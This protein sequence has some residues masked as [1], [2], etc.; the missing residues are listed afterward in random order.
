MNVYPSSQ[1]G[2]SVPVGSVVA[3]PNSSE[4]TS[5]GVWLE[6]NGQAIPSQYKKLIALIGSK[7][8]NY[9]GVFLRGYGSQTLSSWQNFPMKQSNQ[10]YFSGPLG[11][12]VQDSVRAAWAVIPG[13]MMMDAQAKVQKTWNRP[14][15]PDYYSDGKPVWWQIENTYLSQFRL[16]GLIA[17]KTSDNA[18]VTSGMLN[19]PSNT[20]SKKV[21]VLTRPPV[22]STVDRNGNVQTV[23]DNDSGEWHYIDSADWGWDLGYYMN[24]NMKYYEDNFNQGTALVNG[25]MEIRPV[26]V[27]IRYFIKAR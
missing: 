12:P 14:I 23:A 4:P 21:W 22:K 27:A 1:G 17:A 5:G 13:V 2:A 18:I 3:W 20:F 6:C 26:N 19:K 24:T 16:N 15:R 7:T 9:Q 11:Q 8:P 10:K 25:G